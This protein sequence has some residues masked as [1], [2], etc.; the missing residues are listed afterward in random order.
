MY[1]KR[2]SI[3]CRPSWKKVVPEL[4]RPILGQH[5]T[6]DHDHP[7]SCPNL[8]RLPHLSCEKAG[9]QPR[10]YGIWGTRR[11][12]KH[13]CVVFG[14]CAFII[15]QGPL[16]VRF[17]KTFT[18]AVH[19]SGCARGAIECC[20]CPSPR[21]PALRWRRRGHG[22]APH[23]AGHTFSVERCPTCTPRAHVFAH[24]HASQLSLR[25]RDRRNARRRGM[26]LAVCP[27][28]FLCPSGPVM[29]APTTCV[30]VSR[31]KTYVLVGLLT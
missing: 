15:I 5:R 2:L 1:A 14:L 6:R 13:V 17:C 3:A 8:R 27:F 31:Q 21:V 10:V 11:N 16:W 9:C 25:N 26:R 7:T 24:S 22:V 12:P 4:K 23:H 30:C 29:G 20:P 28:C 18:A 19:S